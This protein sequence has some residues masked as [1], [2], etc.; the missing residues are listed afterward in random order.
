MSEIS[1]EGMSQ[2]AINGLA[3]LAKGLSSN[4]KTRD[5]FLN[6]TKTANPDLNI[7]EVDIP[8]KMQG[9]L[10]AEAKKREEL[11]NKIRE[12]EIRQQIKENRAQLAKTK[13]L[14]EEQVQEVEKMMTEK[15]ILNHDTA[16]DFYLSQQ[17]SATPTPST[18]S[19][20]QQVPK[21]DMKQFNG[22]ITQWARNEANTM[23]GQIRSGQ[24]KV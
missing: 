19:G 13:G 11:E 6:L 24:I 3:L 15:G 18:F 22:N 5:Q 16:A 10:D 20:S 17:K 4:S 2:D 23:I 9:M 12:N 7:P 1:L 21:P 8:F 14:S